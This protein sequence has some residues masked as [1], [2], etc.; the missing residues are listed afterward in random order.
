MM[1]F[2]FY[3]KLFIMKKIIILFIAL[4]SATSL[5]AQSSK[6]PVTIKIYVAGICGMCETQIEKALDTK[7][8]V[9]ADYDLESN[10]A[11]ITYKPKKI[12]EDQLHNAINEMGYD[13]DK[14]KAS[15]EQYSRVH[16]C[17]KYREQEKH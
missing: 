9:A 11:T 10:I 12:S 17:C 15:D 13:T 2:S 5:F 14:S 8:V 7:G 6:K 1:S 3:Y 16:D 4:I